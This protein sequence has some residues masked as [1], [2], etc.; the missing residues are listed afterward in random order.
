MKSVKKSVLTVGL[1]LLAGIL[2][3]PPYTGQMFVQGGGGDLGNR[4]EISKA[5]GYHCIFAAPT[6]AY[7]ATHLLDIPV[8]KASED[9]FRSNINAGRLAVQVLVCFAVVGGVLALLR[10]RNS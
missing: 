1:L 7:V 6:P 9:S 3:F 10:K 4:I 8:G 5:I 2:L